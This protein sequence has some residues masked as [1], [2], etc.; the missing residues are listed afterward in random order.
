[1][2][3]S[4]RLITIAQKLANP[5][6]FARL[7]NTPTATVVA[8]GYHPLQSTVDLRGL[9]VKDYSSVLALDEALT[10]PTEAAAN[11]IMTY[12]IATRTAT[13]ITA[14]TIDKLARCIVCITARYRSL[15]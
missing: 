2:L 12:A 14:S 11:A 15:R 4:I 1:M 5:G 9:N 6:N 13:A 3:R 10:S 7:G 8:Y